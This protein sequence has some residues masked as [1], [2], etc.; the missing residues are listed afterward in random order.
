MIDDERRMSVDM[1]HRPDDNGESP[2]NGS[3]PTTPGSVPPSPAG[4]DPDLGSALRAIYKQTVDEAV[5]QEMLD[6][7]KRLD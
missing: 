7:L 1:G 5:P 6:L 4:K 2:V 3:G